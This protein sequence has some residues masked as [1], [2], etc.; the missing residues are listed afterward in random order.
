M[1]ILIVDDNEQNLYQLQVLLG[2]NGY[3]VETATNGAEAL[4]QAR[5]NPPDLI[6]SDILMPVMDGF[7]LCREWGK[8]ERLR[9]IPFIFYSATYTDER[10]QTFALNLGAERFLAKPE[11]PEVIMQTIRDVFAQGRAPSSKPPDEETT[12]LKQY[13]ET[14][15]RKLETKMQQSEQTN[16]ELKRNLIEI[17]R[18]DEALR[19]SEQRYDM[20][21]N[22]LPDMAYMK[23]EEHRHVM[24]NKALLKFFGKNRD[25]VIG[26]TDFDLMPKVNAQNCLASDLK[27]LQ[28]DGI[29]MGEESVNGRDYEIWKYRVLLANGLWGV[30]GFVRDVTE[31]KRIMKV[32]SEDAIRRR[33]LIEESSDGIVV[34]D[35]E[36]NVV[37]A[38]RRYAEMLG[39]TSQEVLKLHVWDWDAQWTREELLRMIMEDDASGAHFDTRHR[40]KDGTYLDVEI[41]T[42]GAVFGERKLVFCVCRDITERKRSEEALQESERRLAEAQNM[43]QLGH[44]MW[45]LTT[46]RVEWSDQVYK[47]FR[48]DPAAFTPRV[49]SILAFSPWPE[50]HERDKELIRK[51]VESHETG[52]YEQKILRQDKSVGFYQST[53]RGKYDEQG[54]LISIVG[55]IL[56]ITERKQTEEYRAMGL[57][58]LHIL[59]EPANMRDSLNSVLKEMKARTGFDAL[60]IRL[61]EGED[62]PFFTQEGFTAD[63][64]L[65]ENTLAS[66]GADGGVCRAKDGNACLECTCGLVISGKTDPS[67]PLFT[68]GGSFW[69]NDSFPLLDLPPNLDPR[70]HPRTECSRHGYASVALIPIRNKHSIVGLIQLNDRR[71]GCFTLA[72]VE[73]LEGIA[74]HIG[75][76]LMRKRAE[77]ALRM[78][79]EKHRAIISASPVP[80]ALNDAQQHITFLNPAFV[81][82][83]GYTLEDIPTL[84]HWWPKACPDP[85]YRHRVTS[86]WQT[87]IEQTRLTGTAFSPMEVTVRCKDGSDRTVLASATSL[88]DAFS[89]TYLVILYDNTDQK[90]AEEERLK[91]QKLQSVGTLAGG[92]AHDFNN[93]MLGVFG[94]I[95]LAKSELAE[96]HPGYAFLEEAEKSMGRAVRLTKQLL[97]FA[98]GGVPVKETVSLGEMVREVA[99]FDLS[100]SSVSLDYRQSPGL[101][102]IEADKGQIQQVV[103]NLVIN[104]RQAMPKGGHLYIT[105]ENASIP[106]AS[107]PGLRQGDYLKVTV[108]DE[109]TGIAP[110]ALERIF[111]PYFTT[112]PSGNGLGLATVWSIITK[113]DGHIGVVSEPGK[114]ATFT[115]YLPASAALLPPE[116]KRPKAQCPAPVR[117]AKILVLDD[118]DSV[119]ILVARMLAPGGYSV[120]T[121]P[122]AQEAI[123][124]YKK[125]LAAGA[126]YDAVI[127][128]LTIPGG[129]GGKEVLKELLPLDPNIRAIV[130]SG[131][132]DDP[133]MANPAAYGFKCTVAKPYTASALREAV[134]RALT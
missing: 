96:E 36:G 28:A 63:F 92:I 44:W 115:F 131:Y 75:E 18:I 26:K 39:Y 2:G 114:G 55:T 59:N 73:L 106:E 110:K 118:D 37:E 1:T 64:L 56:D 17:R 60:G 82:T 27:A 99:L 32:L 43:A 70:H 116:A 72:T 31:Q 103:S 62:F 15:I 9:K 80:M 85:N 68:R 119:C 124:L 107:V 13:N 102:Q 21:V 66:R 87:R 49:D 14:L 5:E 122:D 57:D 120:A 134:A 123:A 67:H 8:D 83:F 38:N 7:A 133:V 77:E 61:Q 104:A 108:R 97:T 11:A 41:S 89:D 45:D 90:R 54:E 23:D 105:L 128:D 40:R 34:L 126:P 3:Q 113:H 101:W 24:A 121:A 125:A 51:A 46:G 58:I 130:S 81:Q 100:G 6:V 20:F 111:D 91:M 25:E 33:I 52:S 4:T 48:L 69:T 88:L 84:A 10:D 132:A 65:T 74:A 93:I 109:G 53:F 117:S 94:N 22:S 98:K 42:N 86:S 16:C 71:K 95:D 19:E 30:V 35:H 127:M 12:Y 76:A 112:K 79:E 78:S 129:P 50:D 29:I 47:I